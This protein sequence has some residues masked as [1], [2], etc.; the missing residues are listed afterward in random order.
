MKNKVPKSR[1]KIDLGAVKNLKIF[2][3]RPNTN[4]LFVVPV[5]NADALMQTRFGE[6][7]RKIVPES[8]KV[9]VVFN[10]GKYNCGNCKCGEGYNCGNCDLGKEDSKKGDG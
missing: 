5:E 10:K 6:M 1:V 3:L 7:F 4:Y 8:S 9:A 2:E